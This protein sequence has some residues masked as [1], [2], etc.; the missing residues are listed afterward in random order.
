MTL[1]PAFFPHFHILG[2]ISGAGGH[3]RHALL[4]EENR[5]LVRNGTHQHEVNAEGLIRKAS[6]GFDFL[7]QGFNPGIHRGYNTQTTAIGDGG[8]QFPVGNPRHASL[9][10]RILYPEQLTDR[11][12]YHRLTQSS[13]Q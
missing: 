3:H 7:F 5:N 2:G 9:Q 4:R 12:V 1:I 6:R 11:C 8:R 10:N 13:V